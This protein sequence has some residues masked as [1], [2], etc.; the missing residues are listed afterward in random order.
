MS[1]RDKYDRDTL[2]AFQS[3]ARSLDRIA[4]S[5]EKKNNKKSVNPSAIEN[6]WTTR[7]DGNDAYDL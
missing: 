5:M 1:V 3:I 6:S 2:K 7:G 4:D